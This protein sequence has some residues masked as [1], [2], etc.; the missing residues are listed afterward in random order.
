[1]QEMRREEKTREEKRREDKRRNV[2]R[3][4]ATELLNDHTF[5]RN[6]A[7]VLTREIYED[8]QIVMYFGAYSTDKN[9]LTFM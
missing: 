4:E 9:L 1:M 7:H 5:C 3:S 2:K 8:M 6:N